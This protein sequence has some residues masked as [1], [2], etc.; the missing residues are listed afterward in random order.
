MKIRSI[1]RNY[2]KFYSLEIDNSQKSVV[3]EE[4]RDNVYLIDGVECEVA[5][6]ETVIY[7]CG[8]FIS[9]P[10]KGQFVELSRC[11]NVG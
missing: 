9:G 6:D 3:A 11:P 7:H 5:M 1:S 10:Y 4:I 2:V 8:V